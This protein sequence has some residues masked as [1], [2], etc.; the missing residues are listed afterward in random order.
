MNGKRKMLSSIANGLH[1]DFPVVIPYV[2]IFLRDHWEEVTDRP[3]WT[4]YGHD[5]DAW[6]KVEEDLQAKLPMD[7]IECG[8]CP[9]AERR[10]RYR[11]RGDGGS[12]VL[13]DAL[14]GKAEDVIQRPPV[15][16]T[17]I[18][19]ERE[20]TIRSVEE[21]DDHVDVI[22]WRAL[23]RSGMLDYVKMVA[24]K[25]G[26]RKFLCASI[27]TPY[28]TA[29]CSYFG[30]KGM[31]TYLI[32]RPGLVERVLTRL[33]ER[34]VEQLKAYADA[35]I[36]GIWVEECLSSANE[37]SLGHFQKF[38]LP[39]DVELISE[40][41]RLGMKSIYYPCGKMDDRLGL[42]IDAKP[43]CISLE[44]SKK[45]FKIDIARVDEMVAGRACIFGNLDAI[46]ILQDGTR[47]AIR[48]EIRRQ[49]DV[50]RR[51]GKFVMSLGSPVTPKT[52]LSRVK[53]YI[54]IVR[55]NP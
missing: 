10:S 54:D 51:H 41:R 36:D 34:A 42:A 33:K 13:V 32:R 40:I 21:V 9:S 50:G 4:F 20:P 31:M 44:E 48:D 7:W 6:L 29:L 12:A 39:Y 52:P 35:G 43:D 8:M 24:E 38:V 2:G 18:P 15:G 53:E 3:W 14:S 27:G 45:G 55:A 28:W 5:L 16:G 46:W 23:I 19:I 1:E 11:V 47:E 17:H 22:D 49:I 26:P 30:L 37:I 25:F